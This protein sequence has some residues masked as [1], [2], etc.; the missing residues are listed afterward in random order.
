MSEM[1]MADCGKE[2]YFR[3][4]S[5]KSLC[6]R[7]SSSDSSCI[8]VRGNIYTDHGDIIQYTVCCAGVP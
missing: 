4:T 3:D 6:R 1:E 8:V 7:S 2:M 5:T